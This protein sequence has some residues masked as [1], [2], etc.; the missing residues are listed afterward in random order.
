LTRLHSSV[1]DHKGRIEY[2]LMKDSRDIKAGIA[3]KNIA[4][5]TFP[6]MTGRLD[7]NSGIGAPISYS[8]TGAMI[9]S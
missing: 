7:F 9:S 1:R 5:L 6:D 2:G 4:G 8:T 3:L